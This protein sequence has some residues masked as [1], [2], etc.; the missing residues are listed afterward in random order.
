MAV[1]RH[2]LSVDDAIRR[3]DSGTSELDPDEAI[4]RLA[5]HGPVAKV[6]HGGRIELISSD[7]LVPGDTIEL[8]EGD[9]CIKPL[10]R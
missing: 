1:T 9:R 2:S 7:Q 5:R 8:E 10:Q 3:L 6:I 4:T